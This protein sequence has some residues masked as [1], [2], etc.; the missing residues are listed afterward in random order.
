[1][2]LS[3]TAVTYTQALPGLFCTQQLLFAR[4]RKEAVVLCLL[5]RA[6]DCH[7]LFSVFAFGRLFIRAPAS[8]LE[9]AGFTRYYL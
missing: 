7:G 4:V 1:M 6:A 3:P 5:A 9:K 8:F 2:V